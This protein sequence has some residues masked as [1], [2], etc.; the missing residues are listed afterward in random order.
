MLGPAET[1]K[2]EADHYQID[3]DFTGVSLTLVI[4]VESAVA[5]EPAEG[6]LHDP[7]SRKHLEPVEVGAF[8]DFDH[9]APEFP[10]AVDQGP[11]LAAVGP[12]VADAPARRAGKERGEQL[13]GPIAI[14]DV[15]GQDHHEEDEAKGVHQEMA[16]AP[17]DLLAGVVAPLVAGLGALDCG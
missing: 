13:P 17:I 6:A 10:G 5:A 11:G 3:H 16:L 12:E 4:A 14:L 8:H 1:G 9:A 7:T 2:H 15:R